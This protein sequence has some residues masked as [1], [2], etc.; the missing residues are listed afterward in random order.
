MLESLMNIPLFEEFSPRQ[1][2]LLKPLFELYSCPKGTVI[3]EQ[4]GNA[5]YLYLILK[6]NV[7]IQYK[8]YDGP[9]IILTRLKAGDVV[10]WSAVVGSP[11]YTS[12]IRSTEAF[13][14]IRIRGADLVWL[15]RE[16]PHTG[17]VILDRLAHVVSTRWKNARLQVKSMLRD[18][19]GNMQTASSRS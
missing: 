11:A 9:P 2:E 5:T 18:S 7:E 19:V 15:C 4:G 10:G 1:L 17:S 14:A 3:F 8:P 16:H 12:S 13:E 6:G